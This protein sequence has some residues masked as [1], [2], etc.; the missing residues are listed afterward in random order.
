MDK[1][2]AK[3]AL[4]ELTLALMYLTR[5]TDEKDFYS[6]KYFQAWKGYDFDILNKLSEQEY[7]CDGRRPSR[8]KSVGLSNKGILQAQKILEKYKIDD[9][10]K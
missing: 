8:T 7:I 5:F 2:E 10:K 4:E 6:A 9:W 3:K 1:T